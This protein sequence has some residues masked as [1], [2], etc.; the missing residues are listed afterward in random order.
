MFVDLVDALRCPAAHAETWLVAAAYRTR[1]R[2]ILDGALGCPECAASYAIRDGVAHFGAPDGGAAADAVPQ[3]PA[4]AADER[5][6]EAMRLAALLDLAGPGGIVALGGTWDAV[7]DALLELA[8]VRVL[9][10]E[11][12]AA[13]APREPVGA[14]R[15][16]LL[17]LASGQVRGIALDA[18]TAT[19]ARLEAAA[20]ALRPRG[21]LVAPIGVALPAGVRE[22]ARDA[23]HWVAER[24][25]VAASA[26]VRLGRR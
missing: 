11:P 17:P 14:A 21:R 3:S 10:V 19:P 13:Y 1:G 4:P 6:A 22:L 12:A 25:A 5:A 23:R 26:I 15:G 20:R 18:V 9:L 16:A 2:V 8:D 24:D 7:A